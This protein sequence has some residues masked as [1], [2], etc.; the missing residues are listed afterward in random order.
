MKER[1]V[2]FGLEGIRWFDIK[3]FY[4]RN[5]EA[6]LDS[7][8]A[9]ERDYEYQRIDPNDSNENVME[10]YELDIP[11]APIVAYPQD[12]FL[13]IPSQEVIYNS[14]LAPGVEAE[15]YYANE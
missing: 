3:R 8:N 14:L 12:M 1:R 15:D 10:G 2:E 9:Q 13:P 7:L 4:Y 6:A 11:T 5:P